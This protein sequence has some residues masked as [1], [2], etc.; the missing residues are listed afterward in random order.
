MKYIEL[1]PVRAHMVQTAADYTWSS[2]KHHA[3]GEPNFLVH[4]YTN[5]LALDNTDQMRHE[6][7]QALF[8]TCIS[9]TTLSSIRDSTNKKWQEENFVILPRCFHRALPFIYLG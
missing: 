5:Y 7:Y 3:Y 1:N 2:Y 9:E 8:Q 6:N 4:H